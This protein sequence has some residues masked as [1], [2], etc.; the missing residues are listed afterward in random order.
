[1][2][3]HK[4]PRE[5]LLEQGYTAAQVSDWGYGDIEDQHNKLVTKVTGIVLLSL[6][7]GVFLGVMGT[8]YVLAAKL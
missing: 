7:T 2:S 8:L 4:D 3:E 5:T 6:G 1:M